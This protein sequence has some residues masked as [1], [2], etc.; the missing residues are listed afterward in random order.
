MPV[1]TIGMVGI[2]QLGLP[3]ATNLL[4]AGFRVIGYRRRD[5]EAFVQQGGIALES[6]AAVAAEP[7]FIL[8]C[9]PCEEAHLEIM[10][11][12]DGLLQSIGLQHSLIGIGTYRKTF[13]QRIAQRSGFAGAQHEPTNY[14]CSC[15][16]P[17][18]V[19]PYG[20]APMTRS[21]ADD[22]GVPRALVPTYYAEY[23]GN[24]TSPEGEGLL[25]QGR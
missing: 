7:D 11:G 6:P 10:E 24:W 15:R 17:C 22:A 16:P 23:A 5:R 20:Q 8:T 19:Q 18:L 25:M 12:P 4:A 2:G 21:R 1:T 3:I 14:L 9:L 13:K